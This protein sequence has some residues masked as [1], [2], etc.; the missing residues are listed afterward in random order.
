MPHTPRFQRVALFCDFFSSLGGTEYC[1]TL[2][3]AALR[4]R[5]LDVRIYIGEKPQLPHWKRLLDERQ[6]PVLEPEVFHAD[7][8]CRGIEQQFVRRVAEDFATW[9]PDIIH[10]NP[11]GKL[12]VSWLELR[13]GPDIPVIATECTTPS[14]NSAHWYPAELPLFI[15]EIA[16][17][18]AGWEAGR[19]GIRAFHRFSGPIYRVPQLVT[20]PANLE[21]FTIDPANRALGCISRL[22][23][24]KGIDYLLGAWVQIVAGLPEASLHL[25]GQGPDEIRLRELADCLGIT[26]T[27]HFEGAF[28]PYVG[29]DAVA[30][31]HTIFVQPS[32]FEGLPIALLELIARKR[33]VIATQVGGVPELL[34][35]HPPAGLL[36]APASTEAIANAVLELTGDPERIA[37]Y[38]RVAHQK[39]L[40]HYDFDASI[41]AILDVYRAVLTQEHSRSMTVGA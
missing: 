15:D 17:F 25:Y 32:L 28:E 31:R 6:I 36:I 29:I 7:R 18:T 39:F 30:G 11:P 26:D 21:R 34:D 10:A 13:A 20:P 4:E 9:R 24:E 1:N 14:A 5:G 33:V 41:D 12:M 35:G 22:S 37:E 3:A 19:A 40:T 8:K 16:A 23:V 27:V 38:S 2:L